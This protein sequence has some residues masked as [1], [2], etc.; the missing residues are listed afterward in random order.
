MSALCHR[1][2]SQPVASHNSPRKE[3]ATRGPQPLLRELIVD[4]R[5]YAG[6]KNNQI[7]RGHPT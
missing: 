5:G 2:T 4:S 7:Y 1:A 6:V 3:R